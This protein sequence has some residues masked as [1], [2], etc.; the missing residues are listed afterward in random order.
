M[1]YLSIP[2]QHQNFHIDQHVVEKMNRLKKL[3]IEQLC[4]SIE[5]LLPFTCYY[6]SP[7][8]NF[9]TMTLPRYKSGLQPTSITCSM[10]FGN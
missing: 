3:R 6:T 10:H 2:F 9:F 5:K 4:S 8:Y 7:Q 1:I